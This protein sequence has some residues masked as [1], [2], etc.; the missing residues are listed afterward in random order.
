M[1]SNRPY[2][3]RGLYEWIIDN[4][5]TPYI[6]L[7]KSIAGC[8]IPEHFVENGKVTL[9]IHPVAVKDL[10]IG[11][12]IILFKARFNGKSFTIQSSIHAVQAIYA[13]ENGKGMIFPDEEPVNS[14]NTG[15]VK[16][17]KKP[18]LRIVK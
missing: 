3:I 2:L 7:D 1:T 14:E 5:M 9:N 17:S 18:G 12:E 8:N 4:N 6:V 13:K 10:E 11:N 16:G 15:Q